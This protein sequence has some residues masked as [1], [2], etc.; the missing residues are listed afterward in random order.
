MTNNPVR[1]VPSDRE[2][3]GHPNDQVPP[4]YRDDDD[5]IEHSGYRTIRRDGY[6]EHSR[7]P[8]TGQYRIRFVPNNDKTRNNRPDG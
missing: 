5:D 3:I 8:D 4:G 1:P 2:I 6:Y 7:N